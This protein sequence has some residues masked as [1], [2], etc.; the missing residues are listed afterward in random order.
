M[1]VLKGKKS[2]VLA[3]LASSPEATEAILKTKASIPLL[4][5]VIGRSRISTL[6]VSP[7]L[8]ARFPKR[9][10]PALEKIGVAVK[11][12]E[13]KRGRPRVHSAEKLERLGELAQSLNAREISKQLGLPIRTVYYYIRRLKRAKTNH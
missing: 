11:P 8:L 2:E 9:A 7:K 1:L 4:T 12:V 13:T 10:L 6:F 5:E 3:A